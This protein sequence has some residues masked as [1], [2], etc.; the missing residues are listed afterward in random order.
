MSDSALRQQL[1]AS[2][3]AFARAPLRPSAASLLKT[4]GYSSDKTVDFG[5]S[6]DEFLTAIERAGKEPKPFDR[7]KLRVDQWKSC[8]FLFQLTNDEI[9][10]LAT[11]QPILGAT[12]QISP[13]AIESLVFVAVELKREEWS[14]SDLA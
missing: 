4:L 9:P 13:H 2:L 8:A 14:R 3:S 1:V 11:G 12:A 10:A 5:T 7:S 6:P